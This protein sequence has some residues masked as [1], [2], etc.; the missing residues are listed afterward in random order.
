MTSALYKIHLQPKVVL[1]NLLPVPVSV[2]PPGTMCT[3]VLMPGASVQ[4]TKA[5]LGMS[6]LNL[7]VKLPVQTQIH[8]AIK[9]RKSKGIWIC[10]YFLQ[11]FMNTV[12]NQ[13][14][15][16]SL[17]HRFST[18]RDVTGSAASP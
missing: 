4:L 16:F 2:E 13:V 17:L 5:Q 6:Y 3:N 1:H 12:V 14:F 7:Q 11:R 18:I 10:K 9:C 15:H 8:T